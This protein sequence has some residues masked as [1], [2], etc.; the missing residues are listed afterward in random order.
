MKNEFKLLNDI[1]IMKR[2]ITFIQQYKTSVK[3]WVSWW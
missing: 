1:M 2:S 3:K